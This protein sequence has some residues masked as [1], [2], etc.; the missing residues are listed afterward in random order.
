M[1]IETHRDFVIIRSD[2]AIFQREDGSEAEL[3][4]EARLDYI[5]SLRR[6]EN[7]FILVHEHG[8]IEWINRSGDTRDIITRLEV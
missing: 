5:Q 3:K 4:L 2:S 6:D 1:I 7:T 8:T